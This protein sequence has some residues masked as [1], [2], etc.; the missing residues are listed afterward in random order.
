[1]RRRGGSRLVTSIINLTRSK[2]THGLHKWQKKTKST[3]VPSST[4]KSERDKTLFCAPACTNCLRGVSRETECLFQILH[5]LLPVF[6][7][8]ALNRHEKK[9]STCSELGWDFFS[10]KI[11]YLHGELWKVNFGSVYL[12]SGCFPLLKTVGEIHLSIPAAY[13]GW[14]T[15]HG[16]YILQQISWWT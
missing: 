12:R 2:M 3:D 4:Y 1:M 15:W 13:Q 9:K 16:V 11:K 7:R 6:K 5:T 8:W 14:Q 10:M